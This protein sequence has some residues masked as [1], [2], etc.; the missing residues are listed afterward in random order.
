MRERKFLLTA[1]VLRTLKFLQCDLIGLL[2]L[3][4]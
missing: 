1:L 2:K 4:F 3:L